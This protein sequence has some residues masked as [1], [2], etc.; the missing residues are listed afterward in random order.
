MCH[1]SSIGIRDKILQCSLG[2]LTDKLLAAR[3][4]TFIRVSLPS[5]AR[6]CRTLHPREQGVVTLAGV[7]LR[8]QTKKPTHGDRELVGNC[9]DQTFFDPSLSADSCFSKNGAD[10]CIEMPTLYGR[11][12][13]T[14][15]R[16]SIY[17]ASRAFPRRTKEPD[18]PRFSFAQR[19]E[20]VSNIHTHT[21]SKC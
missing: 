9:F 14:Q 1:R 20:N 5:L 17:L 16:L 21:G 15:W 4:P 6:F 12:P 10:R 8:H 11:Q 19:T 13:V 7:S 3:T 2:R 18:N